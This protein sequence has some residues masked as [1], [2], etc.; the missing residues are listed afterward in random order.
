MSSLEKIFWAQERFP[1]IITMTLSNSSFETFSQ[2]EGRE[3]EKGPQPDQLN[4][5]AEIQSASKKLRAI[6]TF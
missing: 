5:I 1:S 6:I 2:G 4:L 3:L